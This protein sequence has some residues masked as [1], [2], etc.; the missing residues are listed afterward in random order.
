MILIQHIL[1]LEEKYP[2]IYECLR[3]A[4]PDDL[5]SRINKD[6]L[7]TTYQVDYG[8]LSKDLSILVY[9]KTYVCV[10]AEY[11]SAPYDELF[12]QAG[13]EGLPPCPEPRKLPGDP[14]RPNQKPIAFRS[15]AVSKMQQTGIGGSDGESK[16]ST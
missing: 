15:S 10:L 3:T 4:P 1:K 9:L 14:C 13:V 5:I 11:P 7:R 2:F 16:G 6:R 12:R 8:R